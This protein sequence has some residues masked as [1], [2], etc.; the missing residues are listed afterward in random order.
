MSQDDVK[1]LQRELNQFTDKFL[2]KA[3][4]LIVDGIRGHATNRRIVTCKVLP[5]AGSRR[6]DLHLRARG[7]ASGCSSPFTSG[8]GEQ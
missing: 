2:E 4:P 7:A 8:P 6:L 1:K 3:A 5:V